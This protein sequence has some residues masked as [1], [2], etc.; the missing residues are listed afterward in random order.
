MP[1][2]K[3]IILCSNTAFSIANFRGG[4]IRSLIAEGHKVVV[5]AP[6]DGYVS[7]IE[8]M[9]AS[10]EEWDLSGRSTNVANEIRAM[11]RLRRIYRRVDADLAFHYTIKSVIYGAIVG[12]LTKT[13]FV[14]VI[15]GLGY[16][17]LNKGLVSSLAKA[18]YRLTL[19]WSRS[20]WF[21]NQDD[22]KLFNELRL[23]GPS[24]CVEVLPG[25]GVDLSR[26]TARQTEPSHRNEGL[27]L[28]MVGRLI[29]DKGV[30]ELIEAARNI[31]R[32]YPQ[33]RFRLLGAV[34]DDNPTAIR[35]AQ[36][37]EWLDEG[38][39]EYL[40]TLQDVRPAI[41]AA[42]AVLLPS[43]REGL[44]RSLLEAAAMSKPVIATDVPG[45][46]EVV[47][48]GVS[49]FL[50]KARSAADLERCLITFLRLTP[51]ARLEMGRE[52]RKLVEERFDERLVV[53][54]YLDVLNRTAPTCPRAARPVRRQRS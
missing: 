19:G 11:A 18:F 45:C 5:V 34:G 51:Q 24:H 42:D 22:H 28:L 29:V 4:V 49:G 12:R 2:P 53:G 33:T 36:L 1:T 9:G 43:Y 17:F 44:P 41:N 10:F 38:V 39:V 47:V 27:I 37:N 32:Q 21:L 15:T 16:V 35:E 13:P 6:R 20:I 14:S 48:E 31:R 7:S 54:R 26:F 46:R 3:T 50:C 25:E 40:G 30:L 52:G 8:Q 23:V